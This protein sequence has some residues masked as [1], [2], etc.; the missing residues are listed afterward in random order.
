MVSEPTR[1]QP[2]TFTEAYQDAHDLWISTSHT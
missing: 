1:I 2:A